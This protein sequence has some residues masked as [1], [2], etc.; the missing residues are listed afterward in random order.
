M[1]Q[2]YWPILIV[3]DEPDVLQLTALAMK[4]FTVYGLPLKLYMAASKADAIALINTKLTRGWQAM[5]YLAVAFIDV[6]M[7]NDQAGLELCQHIRETMGNKVSQLYIRTGQPGIAPE[8]EVI[9]L[10]DINGYFTKQ[11]AT[12]D[13]LYSLVKSGVRQFLTL[14]DS[15]GLSMAINMVSTMSHSRQ[16]MNQFLRLMIKAGELDAEGETLE[17]LEWANYTFLGDDGFGYGMDET[18]A[19]A[20]RDKLD[21]MNGISLNVDGDKYVIDEEH[22]TML[23]IVGGPHRTPITVVSRASMTTPET[24]IRIN[25][26][27]LSMF[28]T[29]YA[30]AD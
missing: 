19:M 17:G 3:D 27:F 30:R 20:M 10:Y 1:P 22:N 16:M 11:E 2:A 12:E 14:R 5:P 21:Q 29:L 18:A 8:R 7:E 26:S 23:K 13:K 9:D 6:V 25:H 15:L 4:N 28:A 24:N